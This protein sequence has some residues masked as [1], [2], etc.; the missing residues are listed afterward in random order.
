MT[1]P[2][3]LVATGAPPTDAVAGGGERVMPP[4]RPL[5]GGDTVW[6][7]VA[8]APRIP[9][10]L[11]HGTTSVT[12]EPA[13][14]ADTS[15]PAEAVALTLTC[16][17]ERL[18][19]LVS[20]GILRELTGLCGAAHFDWRGLDAAP[21]RLALNLIGDALLGPLEALL[22]VDAILDFADGDA[23]HWSGDVLKLRISGARPMGEVLVQVPA[24]LRPVL[25]DILAAWPRTTGPALHLR[26]PASIRLAGPMLTL[27][28][29]KALE[30][31]DI[32][33]TA[34]DRELRNVMVQLGTRHRISALCN[35]STA[36]ATEYIAMSD[37]TDGQA[38]STMMQ[39][40]DLEV[41][42]TFEIARFSLPVGA[43]DGVGPGYVF[44]L[45][46]DLTTGTLDIRAAGQRIGRGELVRVGDA[47][48]VQI[49]EVPARG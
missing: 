13:P 33:L 4:I 7:G 30:P 19:L 39:V 31:G 12:V 14:V 27:A 29:L 21:R 28:D 43:L 1:L 48:G 38:T 6:H 40:A 8:S 9:L 10:R 37:D 42:V 20:E 11:S 16:A 26:V 46:G 35:G 15:D 17:R 2:A 41:Q 23:P 25:A 44:T 45:P 32:L 36:T 22:Q 3:P 18:G 5:R 47:I 49:T 34:E 24:P